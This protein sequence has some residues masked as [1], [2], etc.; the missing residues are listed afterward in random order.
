MSEKRRVTC[1]CGVRILIENI[2]ANAEKQARLQAIDECLEIIKNHFHGD[3]F[4]IQS[5]AEEIFREIE[6]LKEK[7]K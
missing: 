4:G 5:G 3:S 6:K 7:G 2:V 1:G